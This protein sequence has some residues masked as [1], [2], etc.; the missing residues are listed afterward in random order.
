MA[1][2]L[3]NIEQ[4]IVD[5]VK[6]INPS[7]N[8]APGSAMYDMIVTPLVVL[9]Q[10]LAN[11]IH[12][13]KKT[14]SLVNESSLSGDDLDAILANI[15]LARS[16]GSRASGIVTLVLRN[17]DSASIS[18]GTTFTSRGGLQFYST[19]SIL[20]S[21]GNITP[22]PSTGRFEIS[23]TVEAAQPGAGYNI[24]KGEI[25][26]VISP[27]LN[28]IGATNAASFSG[29]S[30]RESN[31]T[32]LTRARNSLGARDL[33]TKRGAEILI[34]EAFADVTKVNIAGFGDVDMIRDKI[35]A[36]SITLDEITYPASEGVNIGGKVD[37][38]T[39]T[40]LTT[41]ELE[42][43]NDAESGYDWGKNTIAFYSG[44]NTEYKYEGTGS[45]P[46]T[47]KPIVDVVS[48]TEDSNWAGSG[49]L[50]SSFT[51]TEGRDYVWS[52]NG[53]GKTNSVNEEKEIKFARGS[54]KVSG[55]SHNPS[56]NPDI[57]GFYYPLDEYTVGSNIF[58]RDIR[59]GSHLSIVGASPSELDSMGMFSSLGS[60]DGGKSLNIDPTF[61]NVEL[62]SVSVRA[63]HVSTGRSSEVTG[64]LMPRGGN[65][66][67]T[68]SGWFNMRTLP[69]LG[70][71]RTLF[72]IFGVTDHEPVSSFNKS[73]REAIL[74]IYIDSDGYL[75]FDSK[76]EGYDFKEH[77]S[78]LTGALLADQANPDSNWVFLAFTYNSATRTKRAYRASIK[79]RELELI[80]WDSSPSDPSVQQVDY[81]DI[82]TQIT[83]GSVDA[84]EYDLFN[85]NNSSS[86]S[87]IS[88]K[89]VFDGLIDGVQFYAQELNFSNLREIIKNQNTSTIR[90]IEGTT[91]PAAMGAVVAQF[92]NDDIP[93][94]RRGVIQM[95]SG[96]A[97]GK[98][99]EIV[100]NTQ[101]FDAGQPISITVRPI[102]GVPSTRI[103]NED[104]YA[105]LPYAVEPTLAGIGYITDLN[106]NLY[107]DPGGNVT[108]A[109]PGEELRL[110]IGVK[111]NYYYGNKISDIQDYVDFADTR[112]GGTDILVKHP[113]PVFVSGTVSYKTNRSLTETE[114]L[115]EVK[116]YINSLD[117]GGTFSVGGF[118]NRLFEKG[119]TYVKLPLEMT[120]TARDARF[121]KVVTTD[122]EDYFLAGNNQYFV[123]GTISF[124][125]LS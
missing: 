48:A 94:L 23:V 45:C 34:K 90:G 22:N 78:S 109:S 87:G 119:L 58:T 67:F 19:K 91:I 55:V 21:P 116:A 14:K 118:V 68:L 106:G 88:R 120:F 92:G 54:G 96:N 111:L 5:K 108:S 15:F 20:A 98:K 7:A 8:L 73:T 47:K 12:R 77:T 10:P 63:V 25:S 64:A 4:Y 11:E 114:V 37:I 89:N 125:L 32:L 86:L 79:N 49:A 42:L 6:Q 122:V 124:E 115:A 123:P 82:G 9:M 2:N 100:D 75:H 38:Y 95:I 28:V 107:P 65:H 40:S 35:Y 1:V 51:L 93:I 33:S 24:G 104:K 103:R 44:S 36:P 71:T 102:D 83:I 101:P 57:T 52:A 60:V 17:P 62:G 29:G 39:L 70:E 27:D 105:L 99:F 69:A 112:P 3:L 26:G 74:D 43:T 61:G 16:E 59:N 18:A 72:N 53:P 81:D 121:Q 110:G 85:A 46:T 66:S 31:Q 76:A 117:V 50:N 80:D 13:V 84:G 41:E 97:V 113:A 30:D 56:F